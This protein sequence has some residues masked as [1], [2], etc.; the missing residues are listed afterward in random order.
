MAGFADSTGHTRNE[1]WSTIQVAEE[2]RGENGASDVSSAAGRTPAADV[3]LL[4]FGTDWREALPDLEEEPQLI[5]S[6]M[7]SSGLGNESHPSIVHL[8][9]SAWSADDGADA[10][11][12]SIQNRHSSSSMDSPIGT[13]SE[14]CWNHAEGSGDGSESDLLQKERTRMKGADWKH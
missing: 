1:A 8:H 5:E 6:G 2:G 14:E 7:G 9:W 4:A 3:S 10:A 11:C 12:T 13:A